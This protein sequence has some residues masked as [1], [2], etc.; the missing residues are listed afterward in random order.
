MRPNSFLAGAI[1]GASAMYLLDPARGT[2]RRA[3]LRHRLAQVRRGIETGALP[4]AR[5]LLGWESDEPRRRADDAEEVNVSLLRSGARDFGRL[6]ATSALVG[7]A[8]GA[9]AA[10]GLTRRGRVGG[11]MRAIGTTML[12]SGLKDLEGA[13]RGLLRERRRALEARRSIHIA[14]PLSIVFAFWADVANVPRY[15]AGVAAVRDL[16][17]GRSEWV[18]DSAAG[19]P[20]SWTARVTERVPDRAITWRSDPSG[21]GEQTASFRFTP[22]GSGTRVDARISYVP[23]AGQSDKAAA[24][25][26]GENPTARLGAELERAKAVIET[27]GGR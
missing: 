20:V 5:S 22:A 4:D 13:P 19:V 9:L 11:A 8:G 24:G 23:P 16:G 10:Y 25:L 7:V 15:I 2:E 6:K 17:G 3:R 1:A 26:F 21:A 18:G 27:E 12:A 14:A